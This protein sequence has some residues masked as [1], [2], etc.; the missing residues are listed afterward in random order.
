MTKR[1]TRDRLEVGHG[2]IVT[3]DGK[4]SQPDLPND[5]DLVAHLDQGDVAVHL[6][7][8]GGADWA[9]VNHGGVNAGDVVNADVVGIL[10]GL[11]GVAS[12]GHDSSDPW[13]HG[14]VRRADLQEV[15]DHGWC[16]CLKTVHLWW[17]WQKIVISL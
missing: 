1:V 3:V 4:R 17:L 12:G 16:C 2:V 5:A 14:S 10:V 13:G 7:Q 6:S 15:L 11:G 9:R 8:N